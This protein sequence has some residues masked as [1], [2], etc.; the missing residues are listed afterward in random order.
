MY[1]YT[2]SEGKRVEV[3]KEHIENAIDIKLQ[4][5]NASPSRRTNWKIHKKEMEK[6]GFYDSD[7][8]ESYRCLIKY[9][10]EKQGKL[11]SLQKHVDLISNNRVE[12][13][14]HMVD[15]LRFENIVNQDLL[16]QIRN[17]QRNYSRDLAII[18]SIQD[19]IRQ[20]DFSDIKLKPKPRIDSNSDKKMLVAF[21]D[22]HIGALS[23]F[24]GN[25]FNFEIAKNR[26]RRFIDEVIAEAKIRKIKD[27]VVIDFGDLVE[28]SYMRPNQIFEFPFSQQLTMAMKL[29]FESIIK[30]SEFGNVE[31]YTLPGNHDRINGDKQTNIRGD[32]ASRIVNAFVSETVK[33]FQKKFKTPRI[34]VVPYDDYYRILTINGLTIMATH[35]DKLP[36][37][38]EQKIEK[39]NSRM[40]DKFI[41][42][43]IHGHFHSFG[44]NE[45]S[46]GR[47]VISCGS[48]PGY[49]VYSYEIGAPL[50]NPSQTI[51]IF[52]GKKVIPM[53]IDLL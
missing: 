16:R 51:I 29:I 48:L 39:V 44:V 37:N 19:A 7:T 35:G 10:Q 6:R 28:G 50:S 12:S 45:G 40:R 53:K 15:E 23:E 36:G 9:H 38:K 43:L 20:I 26:V 3:T 2:N 5:Q 4:L 8:N 41:D 27:F 42:I 49:N 32:N 24:E 14:R 47:L 34:K 33:L 18:E 25:K 22:W 30:L 17:Y 1:S 46:H 21:S 31:Y 52:D 13:L 11:H